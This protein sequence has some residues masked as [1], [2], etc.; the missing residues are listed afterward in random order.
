MKAHIFLELVGKMMSAQERY[1][2]SR[3]TAG[4]KEQLELLI[5]SKQIEKQVKA[6]I[7]EGRLEADDEPSSAD[8]WTEEEINNPLDLSGIERP[9][10][11]EQKTLFIEGE[12]D[13][14]KN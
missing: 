13:E 8:V 10:E 11:A 9:N 4:K 6:V 2:A 1:F 14:T 5:A 3:K 12:T 7:R